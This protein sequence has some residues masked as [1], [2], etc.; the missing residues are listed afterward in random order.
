MLSATG[1]EAAYFRPPYGY[2]NP[3]VVS[4]A[5]Q[6]GMQ[7]VLWTLLPGDWKAPSAEWLTARMRPVAR[8]A[9]SATRPQGGDVVC[10]HDGAHRVLGGDR[11]RTLAEA[12]KVIRKTL[13]KT[14]ASCSTISLWQAARIPW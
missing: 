6:L 8:H 13:R 2:R 3:W 14:D 11:T 4:Q 12:E 10:L 1:R 7:T 5:R 9:E